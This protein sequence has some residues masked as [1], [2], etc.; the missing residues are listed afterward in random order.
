MVNNSEMWLVR[1]PVTPAADENSGFNIYFCRPNA[2]V[3]QGPAGKVKG[4][5]TLVPS[6][7]ARSLSHAMF[8][9]ALPKRFKICK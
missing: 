1:E 2:V 7:V 4:S 5:T 6:F 9:W 8:V 3:T